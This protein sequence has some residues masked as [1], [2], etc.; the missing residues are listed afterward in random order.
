MI[1]IYNRIATLQLIKMA[2]LYIDEN[3]QQIS[4]SLKVKV[5]KI[6]LF[7]ELRNI[8]IIFAHITHN[9]F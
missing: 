8:E 2:E 6:E 7:V 1:Y 4:Q 3:I 5:A 9:S